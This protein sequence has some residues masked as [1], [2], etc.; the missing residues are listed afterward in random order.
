[1]HVKLCFPMYNTETHY[2]QGIF[3]RAD[4]AKRRARVLIPPGYLHPGLHIRKRSSSVPW[5]TADIKK[6]IFERDKKKRKAMITKQSTDW[7]VYKTSRNLVNIALRHAKAEYYRNKIAQQNN[8]PKEAWKTI[9]DLLGRSSNETI[10]NELPLM[11][12][13]NISPI[14]ALAWLILSTNPIPRLKHL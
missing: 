1:M 13:M 2:N 11:P 7:D 14:L 3:P 10:I 4:R 6:L 9:N 12:L 8:N 5:V